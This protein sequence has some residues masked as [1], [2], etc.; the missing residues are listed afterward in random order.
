[1]S[2]L[3]FIHSTV[4]LL[5]WKAKTIFKT[6]GPKF[7]VHKNSEDVFDTFGTFHVHSIYV[8]Y[9]EGL[10]EL[11]KIPNI[12]HN[13]NLVQK[14][15]NI[16]VHHYI[17]SFGIGNFFGPYFP[18]FGLNSARYSVSVRIQ[19][20]CGK[21]RTRKTLN[22]DT[23]SA[24]HLNDTNHCLEKSMFLSKIDHHTE[25]IKQVTCC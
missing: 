6:I 5:L 21:I 9:V 7:N 3:C 13:T 25:F 8:L 2:I 4:I 20:E 22:T 1:M 23:L 12:N 10:R 24:V 19:S 11:I 17:K 15:N 16:D 18:A 14:H